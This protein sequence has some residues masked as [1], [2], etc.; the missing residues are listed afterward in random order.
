MAESSHPGQPDPIS[1]HPVQPVDS[2]PPIP[3]AESDPA[4]GTSERKRRRKRRKRR[5]RW[6]LYTA[7]TLAIIAAGAAVALGGWM[8]VMHMAGGE[9]VIDAVQVPGQVPGRKLRDGDVLDVPRDG[10]L[11]LGGADMTATLVGGTRATVAHAADGLDLTLSNDATVIAD[12]TFTPP[13]RL[14]VVS[15][16]VA[17]ELTAGHLR[18]RRRGGTVAIAALA[19]PVSIDRGG[20]TTT[21]DANTWVAVGADGRMQAPRPA[22]LR[23][24]MVGWWPGDEGGGNVLHDCSGAG[25]PWPLDLT[26]AIWGPDGIAAP[27]ATA[28]AAGMSSGQA[29]TQTIASAPV[30]PAVAT[31]LLENTCSFEIWLTRIGAPTTPLT[32]LDITD[33]TGMDLRIRLPPLPLGPGRHD[34][35]VTFGRDRHQ[36][37]WIDGRMHA[38]VL[39]PV[40][41]N[42]MRPPLTLLVTGATTVRACAI[43]ANTL[44]PA[45]VKDLYHAGS[46]AP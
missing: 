36:V 40:Q 43:F 9:H 10:R 2:G 38:D 46:E 21:I 12:A 18:L 41:P 5:S 44:A 17:A 34:L 33:G 31:A 32:V 1:A 8:I 28:T 11:V 45:E 37:T 22:A 35:V 25:A 16:A 26:N 15:G 19:G 20:V 39:A 24:G 42:E 29:A 6:L 30:P 7:L 14:R 13:G 4:D 3:G 23:A 27:S